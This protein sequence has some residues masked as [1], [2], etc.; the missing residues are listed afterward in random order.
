MAKAIKIIVL[1]CLLSYTLCGQTNK[2]EKSIV[3]KWSICYSSKF[4]KSKNCDSIFKYEFFENG[5]YF[6]NRNTTCNYQQYIG[7]KGKWLKKKN[8]LTLSEDEY[9][10]TLKKRQITRKIKWINNDKFYEVGREGKNGPKI[11]TYF[12]RIK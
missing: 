8:K 12:M 2:L 9:C 5:T 7:V 1:F 6:E 11:N 3:G 4:D 10:E